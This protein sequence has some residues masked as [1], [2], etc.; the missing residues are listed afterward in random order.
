MSYRCICL[1]KDN[2]KYETNVPKAECD[3]LMYLYLLKD[4][5]MYSDKLIKLTELIK[6]YGSERYN[7]GD[8]N[9]S[10]Q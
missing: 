9:A 10:I 8:Y 6:E 2:T 1:N 5:V 7:E 4:Q 3:L